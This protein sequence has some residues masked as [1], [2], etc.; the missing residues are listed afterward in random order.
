MILRRVMLVLRL[1]LGAIF[2]Y[3]AWTKLRQPW[4]LFAMSIDSYHLLPEWAVLAVGRTLP[5]LELLIGLLLIPG[6]LLRYVATAASALLVVFF[7][8]ML[9]SYILGQGISCGC[10]GIGEAISPLTLV[11]D[12]SLLAAAVVLTVYAFRAAPAAAPTTVAPTATV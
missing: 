8:A 11:R 1:A 12:G 6:V 4:L 10:F 9:R 7:A 5:W 3:A 2:I